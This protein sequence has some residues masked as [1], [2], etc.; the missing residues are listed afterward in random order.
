M[1]SEASSGLVSKSLSFFRTSYFNQ[2]LCRQ[3]VLSSHTTYLVRCGGLRVSIKTALGPLA[4]FMDMLSG[5][6]RVTLSSD[7][8]TLTADLKRRLLA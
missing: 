5:E 8:I 7:D 2:L 1:S 3:K 6:E 4:N